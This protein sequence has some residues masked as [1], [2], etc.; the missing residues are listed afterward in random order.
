MTR[1][2][3][4]Y[5]NLRMEFFRGAAP[6]VPGGRPGENGSQWRGRKLAAVTNGGPE[7]GRPFAR[8]ANILIPARR[9]GA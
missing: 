8:G 9:G 5:E 7:L 3:A 2:H 6:S 1:P 4:R